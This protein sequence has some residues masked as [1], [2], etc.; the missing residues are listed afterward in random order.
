MN[1]VVSKSNVKGKINAPTSKSYLQRALAISLLVNGKTVILSPNY[2][3][4][5]LAAID[6]IS[7][8]GA[9]V[10]QLED[11]IVVKSSGEVIPFSEEINSSE[12]GL[13]A[14]MFSP[15]IALS[16]KKVK[17]CVEGSLQKRP[18]TMV[19]DALEKIGAKCMSEQGFA[20][21]TIKGPLEASTFSIDA[22]VSS[23]LL[24]GLLIAL[25]KAQGE[26]I[27][28]VTSLKS[29]PY[30]DITIDTLKLFE[31]E[32]EHDD[33]KVFRIKG[34]QILK[35]K[36]IQTEGDWSSASFFLV[37]GVIMGNISV[38]GLS[39]S[40]R[41]A[42]IAILEAIKKANG[43]FSI[44][45]DMICLNKSKLQGFNF[46]ATE[47]PDLFPPLVALASC[48]KGTSVIT[49]TNRLK[50]KESN[51]ALSLKEAYEKLGIKINLLDNVMKIEGGTLK[52]GVEIH[53]YNDHR[54]AMATAISAI[55]ASSPVTILNSDC[56]NKSYPNFYK[57]LKNIG[58]N[59]L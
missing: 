22:S 25:T 52:G 23:Q 46:D 58:G 44:S 38:S 2:C 24:T 17:L 9:E 31:G 59:V 50:H 21:L 5:V 32:I 26:S 15:I 28:N 7:N 48:C 29:K 16:G 3:N 56:I 12:S 55:N 34:D 36:K 27:I 18:L 8:L 10:K 4:D 41:Q 30:I 53:S 37:L 43:D 35:A 13:S 49:G 42:D 54:I 19:C 51:R 39:F 33:Y 20:P 45:D 47:C 14:R 6:I 40:S 1:T 57:D 11:R